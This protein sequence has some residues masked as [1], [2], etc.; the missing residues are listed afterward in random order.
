MSEKNYYIITDTSSREAFGPFSKEELAEFNLPENTQ[1]C[2]PNQKNGTKLAKDYSELANLTVSTDQYTIKKEDTQKKFYIKHGKQ[3]SEYSIDELRSME[4]DDK[5][6]IGIGSY[7]KWF[8][9][10]NVNGL[11]EMINRSQTF[12]ITSNTD[13]A[14]LE[15]NLTPKAYDFHTPWKEYYETLSNQISS[16][17]KNYLDLPIVPTSFANINFS[18]EY[19][20]YKQKSHIHAFNAIRQLLQQVCPLSSQ[21]LEKYEADIAALDALRIVS[22]FHHPNN[23]ISLS[24]VVQRIK[25]TNQLVDE[26]RNRLTPLAKKCVQKYLDENVPYFHGCW[27]L[28]PAND[29]EWNSFTASSTMPINTVYL[30]KEFV[31]F[32]FFEET[33]NIPKLLFIDIINTTNLVLYYQDDTEDLCFSF[34]N[35]VLGRYLAGAQPG[36]VVI[37]VFDPKGFVG[38]SDAFRRKL[39]Y[40]STDLY[41]ID[42]N[43]RGFF[44]GILQEIA[45]RKKILSR[46][47]SVAQYN[48]NPANRLFKIAQ[49]FYLIIGENDFR[50]HELSLLEDILRESPTCGICLIFLTKD[51]KFRIPENPTSSYFYFDN[52]AIV[53]NKISHIEY[54]ILSEEQLS[55]ICQVVKTDYIN[56]KNIVKFTDFQI[57][58]DYWWKTDCSNTALIPFGLD[59]ENRTVNLAFTQKDAQNTTVVIGTAGSGKS[60]FIHDIILSAAMKYSPKDLQMYLIDFSGAEFKVYVRDTFHKNEDFQYHLPHALVVAPEV[61]REFGLS[62][63]KEIDAIATERQMKGVNNLSDYNKSHPDKP[64]PRILVI[65]D[66]YQKFF[67]TKTAKYED[68]ICIEARKSIT[69]IIKEYRKFGINLILATQELINKATLP[70]NMIG[71]HIVFNSQPEDFQNLI[72]SPMPKLDAGVCVY[73]NNS[74]RSAEG[75]R[76]VHSFYIPELDRDLIVKD[77]HLHSIKT[78]CSGV[79]HP[80]VFKARELPDIDDNNRYNPEY[81]KSESNPSIIYPYIGES[82]EISDYYLSFPLTKNTSNNILIAGGD[83]IHRVPETVAKCLITSTMNPFSD[84]EAEYFIFNFLETNHTTTKSLHKLFDNSDDLK[85]T[86]IESDFESHLS[87]IKSIKDK[88]NKDTT[89]WIFL[90]IIGYDSNHVFSKELTRENQPLSDLIEILE[91]GPAKGITTIIQSINISSLVGHLGLKRVQDHF[92]HK[93]VFQMSES[94]SRATINSVDAS[95]IS[96]NDGQVSA[97]RGFYYNHQSTKKTKFRPFD[98]KDID[99]TDLKND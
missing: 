6:P 97:Y 91:S 13:N 79:N 54:N 61:E 89:P 21:I 5:T 51:K 60:V 53:Q 75:D 14:D 27:E 28:T 67:E 33:L 73:N 58:K 46:K 29:P 99:K 20:E 65:I 42:I 23:T 17:F 35:S 8:Y 62:I 80:T 85:I 52:E 30:G 12:Q 49:K 2:I 31:S 77:I 18:K 3:Y 83:Y 19:L 15:N 57:P 69:R 32:I 63:L 92:N 43:G 59:T 45:E 38:T 96:E 71:N 41:S 47:E 39:G 7:N 66:E 87:K 24:D 72:R 22:G 84:G 95:L 4:F 88:R 74:G 78:N 86:I 48:A 1:I 81:S 16:F 9:F 90:Y 76:L 50:D 70:Y 26:I 34:I 36:K 56:N 44:D 82:I 37:K 40:N 94:D 11:R 64:L 68:D 98:D 93:I 10:G 55:N 25:D